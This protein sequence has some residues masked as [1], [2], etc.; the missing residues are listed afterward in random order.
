MLT[1]EQTNLNFQ[2]SSILKAEEEKTRVLHLP[3]NY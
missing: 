2:L 3:L 1:I